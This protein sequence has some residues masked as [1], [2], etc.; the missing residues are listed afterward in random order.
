MGYTQERGGAGG[1]RLAGTRPLWRGSASDYAQPSQWLAD[2]QRQCTRGGPPPKT[3]SKKHTHTTHSRT[4]TH[5]P[6]FMCV[7]VYAIFFSPAASLLFSMLVSG[8]RAQ[9]G[10]TKWYQ[11]PRSFCACRS[12]YLLMTN[13][14]GSF[15]FPPST[16]SKIEIRFAYA[17]KGKKKK[18][19]STL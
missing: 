2:L 9:S 12:A 13:H 1:M 4:L 6:L 15:L 8:P 3:T 10:G 5:L 17:I 18:H 16:C 14:P 19:I 7:C 11:L